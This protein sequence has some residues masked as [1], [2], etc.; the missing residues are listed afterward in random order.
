MHNARINEVRT[1]T[2]NKVGL[3]AKKTSRRQTRVMLIHTFGKIAWRLCSPVTRQRRDFLFSDLTE[4]RYHCCAKR[5]VMHRCGMPDGAPA[6]NAMHN[7]A[8]CH[9]VKECGVIVSR[10]GMTVAMRSQNEG[11]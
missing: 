11:E 7:L 10:R 8:S 5:L 1:F 9:A 2:Q 4:K 6:D 3:L